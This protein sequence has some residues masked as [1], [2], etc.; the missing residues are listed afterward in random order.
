M[1]RTVVEDFCIMKTNVINYQSF[2]E[3]VFKYLKQSHFVEND[4]RAAYKKIE[5]EALTENEFKGFMNVLIDNV[6]YFKTTQLKYLT[7]LNLLN[8]G[9]DSVFV[10]CE[11]W[12]GSASRNKITYGLKKQ[13]YNRIPRRTVDCD[14]LNSQWVSGV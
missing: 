1:Y 9:I 5:C 12:K 14:I 11:N 13:I 4:V 7:D 2:K 3:I 8:Y 10:S 6:D